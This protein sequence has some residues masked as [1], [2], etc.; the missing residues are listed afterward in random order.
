MLIWTWSSFAVAFTGLGDD[1]TDPTAPVVR[2]DSG[3]GEPSRV[4]VGGSGGT[5]D[6]TLFAEEGEAEEEEEDPVAGFGG[7]AGYVEADAVETVARSRSW[8]A[9]RIRSWMPKP[10]RR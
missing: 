7:G 4:C 6:G 2:C 3:G 10:W 5:A 9:L 1:T 8:T